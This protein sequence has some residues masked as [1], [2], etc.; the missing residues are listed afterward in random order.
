MSVSVSFVATGDSFITRR[1]PENKKTDQKG[2][3]ELIRS[4]DVRFTNFEVTTPG[5]DAPPSAFSGGTWASAEEYVIEDLLWFGFNCVNLATNHTLDYLYEGLANTQ[6][7]LEKRGLRYA[8]AGRNLAE[9]AS[10]VYLET[11][12]GRVALIGT[13]STFHES[14]MAGNQRRD[15]QGRPGVNGLRYQTVYQTTSDKLKILTE[16]ADQTG[17]N[18]QR[19]LDKLEGFATDDTDRHIEFGSYVF[20]TSS[21]TGSYRVVNELDMDRVIQTIHDAKRQADYVLVSFHSHE[22]EGVHKN[23]PADFMVEASRRFI[24]AGAHAV[25][26]HGPHILRGLEIYKNRP[27]FY[28]LGNFIFQNDTVEKLPADFYEKYSLNDEHTVA[29]ALDKR[30]QNGKIGLGINPD[31]WESVI[32]KWEMTDGKLTQLTLHPIEMGFGTLRYQRGWP[33]LS[34]RSEIISNLQSLSAPFGTSI[35]WENGMGIV[36]LN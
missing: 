35:R 30:S 15:C 28:S 2:I 27:I 10:P 25:L 21:Q 33:E 4:A 31:V 18:D 32:A 36:S 12:N 7:G 23:K 26:G 17:V 14:W 24:D 8:G 22:M 1:L 13:T 29:D 19:N 9:A 34:N 6:K 11:H 5:R 16:I 3:A 20:E